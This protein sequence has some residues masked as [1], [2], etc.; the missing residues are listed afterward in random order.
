[1]PQ[2]SYNRS[3]ARDIFSGCVGQKTASKQGEDG[4]REEEKK[5]REGEGKEGWREGGFDG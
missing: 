2:G 1:M 4:G 5:R 3:Q